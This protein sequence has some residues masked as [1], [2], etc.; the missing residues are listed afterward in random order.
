MCLV[1]ADTYLPDV[2][3]PATSEGHALPEDLPMSAILD[4]QAQG[5][6]DDSKPMHRPR[7]VWSEELH[8][9]FL[10]AIDAAG[11]DEAAVPTVI[12]KVRLS[13]QSVIPVCSDKVITGV[14]MFMLC[15]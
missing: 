5:C 8:Q 1:K 10:R 7:V 9:R 15:S 14:T 4:E 11:S 13:Q 12:L 3:V 2:A 6:L